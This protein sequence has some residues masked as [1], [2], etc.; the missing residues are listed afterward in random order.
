MD[1][2]QLKSAP[3]IA[4]RGPDRGADDRPFAEVE[5]ALEKSGRVED[6]I[7]LYENRSRDVTAA[8]ASVLLTR[9]AELASARLKNLARAETLLRRSLLFDPDGRD[10]L[11]ALAELFEQRQEPA[12]LADSY[13]RIAATYTGKEAAEY[14]LKAAELYEQKLGKRDRAILS[15]QLATRANPIDRAPFK[16]IR[17]IFLAEGRFLSAFE[18]LERERAS[19]GGAGMAEAYAGLAEKL[20]EEPAEHGLALKALHVAQTLDAKLDAVERITKEIQKFEHGWR[21]RVR[22]L[23][24][25]SLEERDR[26]VAARLSLHVAKLLSFYEGSAAAKVKEALDRCFL[27]WPAMPGALQ[28]LEQLAEN[29][30][31]YAATVAQM[32]RMAADSRDRVVQADLLTRAG[33]LRLTRMDDRPGA[34]KAFQQATQADPSRSAAAE[35]CAELHLE[36]GER[37]EAVAVFE[38]YL[39]TVKDRTA[40]VV[41]HLRLADLCVRAGDNAAAVRGHL[42]AALKIE[43]ANAQAAFRLA[44][45]FAGDEDLLALESVLDLALCAGSPVSER[46]ALCESSALLYDEAGRHRDAFAARARALNLDPGRPGLLRSVVETAHKAGAQ[47]ELAEALRRTAGGAPGIT[48]LPLWRNLAQVLQSSLNQPDEAG[49][50][51][52][53]VLRRA[54]DDAEAKNALL[55]L[56]QPKQAAD[57]AEVLA[58]EERA[59]EIPTADPSASVAILRRILAKH[60]DD[61]DTWKRLAQAHTSLSQWEEVARAAEQLAMLVKAPAERQEWKSKLAHLYAERLSRKDEAAELYLELLR[62]GLFDGSVVGGLERLAAQGIRRL[63]ISKAV[64]PHYAQTGD[65]Q[66]QVASLLVQLSTS[67]DRAEQKKL[68]QLLASTH[69][70]QLADSRG[71]FDFYLRGLALEPEDEHFHAEAVRLADELSTRAEL[72]RFLV[73]LGTKQQDKQ[74]LGRRLML[75]GAQIA[76]AGGAVDEAGAAL[77]TALTQLPDNSEILAQLVQ[78][79]ACAGR[80][81]E[82]DQVLRRQILLAEGNE[83]AKLYVKLAEISGELG[84][85]REGAQALQEAINA[86]GNEAELL[87]RMCQLLEQGGRMGELSTALGRQV[88][89]AEQAGDKERASRLSLKRAQILEASLGDRAAAVQNYSDILSKNPSDPDAL[90]A[91]EHLLADEENREEA[92][93][94]LVPAY[95]AAK[96]HRKLVAALDVIADAA[97]DSL[98]KVLALKQAAYVHLHQLRQPELAFASLAR[99]LRLA[100]ADLSVR[101]AARQAAEDADALDSYAEVVAEL[102]FQGDLGN[103]KAALH[104]ELAEVYEKKLDNKREAI[105]QLNAVLELEP[106]QPEPLR[107]LARLYRAS[108]DWASLAA[109][110]ERLA[111]LIPDPSEKISLLREAG[112][113]HEQRL[114][115]KESAAGSWRQISEWDPL[116]REAAASLERLYV[117]L[118]RPN[119]LAFALELRRAQEGQSPQGREFSFKLA[120]LR[121]Q[122]GDSPNALQLFR[123]IL[124]EDPS[125]AN[126]RNELEQW[127]MSADEESAAA[128]E[129]LDPTLAQSGDHDRR[130]ALRQARMDS[131]L[132][133]EKARLA[134]EIR[135]IYERDLNQPDLA[136]MSALRAFAAGV[137][138][139]AIRPELERLARLTDSFEDLVDIYEAAISESDPQ[140]EA[141]PGLLRRAAELREQLAQ[142]EE[143]IKLWQHLLSLTPQDRQAL[144]ALS[145]LFE[146]SQNAKSLSEV[147]AKKAQL[148]QAPAERLDL[149]IKAGG[150]YEL[151]GDESAAIDALRQALAIRVNKKGLEALD[152]LFGKA[153]R[154]SEQ[155]DILDQ[156]AALAED[157]PARR[158]YVGR[159]A[160]LLEK[161]GNAGGAITAYSQTLEFS[162]GDNTAIAGLERLLQNEQVRQE[163]ARLLEPFYR[164]VN[165]IKKLVEVLD[166]RL[167]AAA[168]GKRM[169]LINEVATLREALGQ[170]AL[171]FSARMRAFVENPESEDARGELERLAAD[172]GSFEELAAAFED[173]LEKGVSAALTLELWKRLAILYGERLTRPDLAAR[174]WEEVSQRETANPQ[175][176]EALARLHRKTSNFKELAQ[177]MRRQVTLEQSVPQQITLLFELAHLAEETLADKALAAECYQQIL[178]RKPDDPNAIKFLSRVLA[179]S[180]RYAELATLLGKEIQLSDQ[181]KAH[182]EA[183]EQMVRLGRLRLTRLG[184]PRGALDLFNE[185]LNRRPA[186]PGAVGALEEM[187]RSESPLR[188]EAASA[189]EPI[190]TTGGDHLK[191][192]QMLESRASMEPV[193][194]ERAALLCKVARIYAGPM[195]NAEMAFLFATRALRELPDD[196]Q[197]LA[198][199]VEYVEQAGAKEELAGLLTE[200]A[201]KAADDAARTNLYRA[202]ARLEVEEGDA[203]AAV[204]GWRRVL[205]LAPSDPEALDAV[206]KLFAQTGRAPELLEVLR[207]Q[208]SM[209]EDTNRRAALLFQIGSL[210][211]EHMQDALGALATFRRLLELKP[212][213]S[214]ALERMEQLCFKQER[215][216]ELADV[217]ARRVAL[218]GAEEGIEHKYRLGTLRESKLMD[219]FGALD[220]YTQVLAV[221]PNHAN[222]LA[223]MEAMVAREPSNQTAVDVLL[224]AY[225][226]I[227]EVVKLAALIE[228]RINVSPDSLERKNLLLELATIRQ[229]QEEPELAYLA[230]YRAFKEDPND[231]ELR[232][233]LESA[234]DAAKTFDELASAYEEELP[235][236]AEAADAAQ[237]CL[238]LGVILDQRLRE[239][240]RAVVF[241]EK[242][243][244]LDPSVWDKALPA[245][246]RLYNQLNKPVECASVLEALA[247]HTEDTQEKVGLLFRLGQLSQEML[248]DDDRA[249]TVYEQILE[250]DPK[251]LASA[252]L[253]EALYE[254]AQKNDKLYAILKLE[255]DLVAGPERERI[256]S[257]MAQ[258]SAE[259]L[260]DVGHSIELYREL[261]Q[262]N[263]RNEQAFAALEQL[264]ERGKR[265]EE[266]KELLESKLSATVDPRELVRLSDRLGRVLYRMLNRPEEA[267]PYFKAALERDARHRGALEAMRDIYEELNKRDELVTVLRRLVPLQDGAEGVKGI[268]IR[269]AEVLAAMNRREEALDAARRALEVEPHHPPE[270]NR[271]HDIFLAL[272]AFGD[273][274]RALE[275][276]SELELAGGDRDQAVASLFQIEELWSG[277]A[278]KPESA[279]PALEKIL[280]LDPA[281]RT[282]Y[283]HATKLYGKHNDWRSYAQVQDR[284]LP[285]LVTEDEKVA[286]M[287][288]LARIQEQKLG[289]KD[290]AFLVMC[291]ALQLDAA[292]DTLREEVERLAEET[293]SYEELAAV[294]E[295]V[296]DALPRG[297]LAEKLYLTLA[298]VHDERLDDSTASEGALRKILEFDPTNAVALDALAGMFSRRGR[299]KEY[300]V[301]LEQKLEAAGSIEERKRIL[302]EIARVCA[303]RL[304]DPFESAQALLRSLELEPDIETLQIL[305]QLY[306]RQK[307]WSDVA[308]TL[309]RARDLAATPEERAKLQ[310][311]VSSVYEREMGDDEGAMEGYRVSLE[312]DPGSREAL[313]SLERLYTKLDRPADLLAVYERQLELTNDYRERVKVLFKSASIWEDKYQNLAHADACIEGVLAVDPQNLQAIRA[314]ERLRRAQ[315]RWEELIGVLERHVALCR[316][317]EEQAEIWVEMGDVF[318][319]QLK[320]VDR[321]VNTYH[322]ALELNPRSRP[323]MHALGTLYER[324]GNWPHALDMLDQ[325]AQV[326][327]NTA[328]AVELYHRMGKINEDMLMDPSS[329]KACYL[330][331]LR[332]DP[333]Y[334][335]CIRALKGIH[336]QEKD[337][338]AYEKALIQE[339]QETEDPEAKSRALLE[340]AKYFVE[341]KEDQ[342]SAQHWYE[343]AHRLS[344]ESEDVARP[345]ADIYITKESWTGGE[346][347]LDI[348]VAR[349][350]E[351]AANDPELSRELC[352]QSYR[353]GYVC[354]KLANKPKALQAYERAYQL[355]ATYLPALEGLG[356]LLVQAKR[357]EE[358]L[359]VY[360]TI[361]IHHRDDL[362]D[363]EVVEIYWQLGDVHNA[364]KQFDRAQNHFEKALAIDPSHEPS[365]RALVGLADASSKWDK[366]AEYRQKLVE[367]LDGDSKLGIYIELGMLAREKLKDAHMA[368]DAYVGAHKLT[369]EHLDVMD[370]LY[371]LYRE[372][373]QGQ[374]AADVLERMLK[375]PTLQKQPLKAKRVYFALG[376]IARDELKDADR[377][378]AAF[379]AALDIDHRF[380]EA[381]S[382][383]EALLGRSKQWKLLEENYARMIQRLPKT[384]ETHAARMTLWRALGDLYLKVLKNNDGALM[385]YQVVAA[386]VP[387][388]AAVQEA[389]AEL[390]AQKPGSEEKAVEAYRRALPTTNNPGKVVSALAELAAKRKD[391]DSAYLAA[392]VSAGLIGESGPGEREIL[393]KLTPYA[394]K[395]EVAQRALTDRLWQSH[396]FH[397]KVRGAIGELMAILYEQAGA[398]YAVPLANYNINPK[399]HRIDVGSAQEYQIHHYRYVARLLGMETVEL[400]SPFLVA[401]RERMTKKSNEP[402]PEPQLGVDICH[403]QPVCLKVGGKFFSESGQKEVYYLL[404][405][406]MALLRPEL[407]LSQ[408]LSA[409][410]LEAVFQAA[411]SM[412]VP[413]FRFTA[414]PTA[415]N[416]E[417]RALEKALPEPARAALARVTQEYVRTATPN[418]LRAY[419]EGAELTAV[420][421]GLFVAGEVEPVKKMVMGESGAT[422]RVPSRSKIRDLMV[423]A[424][425]EDLHALRAAVGT[426]VEVQVRR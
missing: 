72:A 26:K 329:A 301:A 229:G 304:E 149:L 293:G 349:M 175:V 259:G 19:L 341:K 267:V 160:Q 98:E 85:P 197:S 148:A 138:R 119:E 312:F 143:A 153:H 178:E 343:E 3:A 276:R 354:E 62:E 96:E 379:N 34:L 15:L 252:R 164:S 353:L 234:A 388:D 64:A 59:A 184:D 117:D 20:I 112:V 277:P 141:L 357:Y 183:Y 421:A 254:T 181:R 9:A 332:I 356:N 106:K 44:K 407:A 303:E 221:R 104:R 397:P 116:D 206:G 75:A 324:S 123:Q 78:L 242:A 390:A 60:P 249:A 335:P 417:R 317:L 311:E 51:W 172:T 412:S 399:K 182:E 30:Q 425:S 190:F 237:I 109:T 403:T 372:T 56:T 318:H 395:K 256:L 313:D 192:V 411:I 58:Q 323:A 218:L 154:Y 320:H 193:A 247:E 297:P 409:E 281:N 48:G 201:T 370:A 338:D 398:L 298:R 5:A 211:D 136:F 21:D 162:P 53:E 170:K 103:V 207:R 66:R 401:T 133:Q 268:R 381:F 43:P 173:Q 151:A 274:V 46:V 228:A 384:E 270:L 306:R 124:A 205:E 54:P 334:L 309:L 1:N 157:V 245:L 241:Y 105:G 199:C 227:D 69:E 6:L 131:A 325:E 130:V 351:R 327:G 77:Q 346:K 410:R 25:Q 264:L 142:P 328:E 367:V 319:Q 366:A 365:L 57:P 360:Q 333:A 32:E 135:S 296:A 73:D 331:A 342:E 269:L 47:P 132:P 223:R 81:S 273:A 389:Y 383:M 200:V 265:Y 108:E 126:A 152:R 13:E 101:N 27:L 204:E 122:Y 179:E 305:T 80:Y 394:K 97:E 156:L 7:R 222:T 330:Q 174:A 196:E 41:M 423:F 186:H 63:E 194:Q 134:A 33:V 326:A 177:V 285:H 361:L 363:L 266:L 83:K 52:R 61:A 422:F 385:A 99:A 55:G 23:K 393:T 70:E 166:L 294:Y 278:G 233:R 382:A 79:Y 114:N 217:L 158:T 198:L 100:P 210:Q 191:L 287:R 251:H 413:N 300:I 128:L 386:G 82:C 224:Q 424:L 203:D 176:L 68:L 392:Q 250:V 322:H 10:A 315:G 185:V 231:G 92:A 49:N 243:R 374:K 373:R 14:L 348:V 24:A 340:V 404:G 12:A 31:T 362:T 283:E 146:K 169:E 38:K 155:A 282:A 35:L 88:E 220:L 263:P 107:S 369:P 76:E 391:Y 284:Y 36:A 290:V 248:E 214:A 286:K 29:S 336:E 86:G 400:F 111:E 65:H 406:T 84:R 396:L 275:L 414:D 345:L 147:Y 344:P 279:G 380:I 337:W 102:L 45:L 93:R 416:N 302:R 408:R 426:Q 37:A 87:P 364:L 139:E 180:E 225:R 161:E 11:S 378:V 316:S 339:A 377:A 226:E 307:Q 40:Q 2:R 16:R 261:L 113:L 168:Q 42:E 308:N 209:T 212:E 262:K 145:R 213:D 321:A 257:R 39:A 280:E 352:R 129:I 235:R 253:L 371:V 118:E 255:R 215:W 350:G 295:E 376:E 219:K 67:Q 310:V 140:D 165:D 419:L 90:A 375:Q 188:G 355:D 208:L 405:R 8:E 240:Q 272:K 358:A 50:A 402:A 137:D 271:V 94:A 299:E 418:D 144:D 368:I 236:I 239:A 127:A 167:Q 28:L 187:A 246:D 91:L 420:R 291:R 121:K 195:G 150:A 230:L 244:Q 125:H 347:M 202:L 387:E 189:L 314:L 359:K 415:R 289:Q 17:E 120:Q 74:G 260:S 216:P 22:T 115:D 71:A 238:K 258:V 288:E 292:D 95:E 89:L 163:A 171:A 4:G 18:S 110:L 159:R 232:K